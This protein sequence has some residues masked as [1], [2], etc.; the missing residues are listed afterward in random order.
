MITPIACSHP[1]LAYAHRPMRRE[2]LARRGIYVVVT[3][4]DVLAN[5]SFWR[6]GRMGNRLFWRTGRV[7][8][9]VVPASRSCGKPVVLPNWSCGESF[10]LANRSRGERAPGKLLLVSIYLASWSWCK[11]Q[12]DAF[13]IKLFPHPCCGVTLCHLHACADD[14]PRRTRSL[15]MWSL[16]HAPRC[17]VF[18]PS[19]FLP[20]RPLPAGP[21]P[22]GSSLVGSSLVGSYPVVSYPVG[23]SPVG[24]SPR[25]VPI[26]RVPPLSGPT[27][28]VPSPW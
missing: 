9:R 24:S 21:S 25:L 23:S 20:G 18:L 16:Y 13:T 7:A 6:T 1:S 26:Q 10:C 3:K 4:P 15:H 11:K 2:Q 12:N 5:R 19:R 22:V 14:S 28:S 17:D 27:W 8:N